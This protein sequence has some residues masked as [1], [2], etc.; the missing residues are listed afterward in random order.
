M[1]QA[2]LKRVF[3][4]SVHHAGYHMSILLPLAPCG[5]RRIYFY[6]PVNREGDT[7]HTGNIFVMLHLSLCLKLGETRLI[8]VVYCPE[9][10]HDKGVDNANICRAIWD[11]TS[12]CNHMF[13]GLRLEELE[14]NLAQGDI[15]HARPLALHARRGPPASR[16]G[17]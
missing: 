1:A 8:D 2:I 11:C 13:H 12:I 15:S 14:Y 16:D 17:T 4:D 3:G 7:L 6:A 10:N 9:W 5:I